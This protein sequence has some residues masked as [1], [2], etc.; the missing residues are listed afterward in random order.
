MD[1]DHGEG[2]EMDK[3]HGEGKEM[4]KDHGER[5]AMDKDHG[6]VV[7]NLAHPRDNINPQQYPLIIASFTTPE[8]QC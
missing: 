1:K 8:M 5:K 7:E 6:A 3:D 4:D 2:K